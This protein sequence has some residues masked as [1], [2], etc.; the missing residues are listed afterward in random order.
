MAKPLSRSQ[1]QLQDQQTVHAVNAVKM[2]S[3]LA[4]RNSGYGEKRLRK[5]SDDFNVILEDV[6]N[7]HL[8]LSDIGWAIKDETGLSPEGLQV[9]YNG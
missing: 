4:L 7:E 8:S 2:I 5:F 3:I 6:S 1:R 9:R